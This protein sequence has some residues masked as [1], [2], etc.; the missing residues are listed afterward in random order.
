MINGDDGYLS[1]EPISI[2]LK[3]KTL[4][5]WVTIGDAQALAGAVISVENGEEGI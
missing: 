3:E 4:A 2:E 1:T 5:A